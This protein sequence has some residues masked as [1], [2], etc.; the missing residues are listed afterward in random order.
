MADRA[1]IKRA[2]EKSQRGQPLTAAES[3]ALAQFKVKQEADWRDKIYRDVPLK[4]VK[5]LLGGRTTKFV[6][7][8][9]AS[10]GLPIAGESSDLFAVFAALVGLGEKLRATAVSAVS[11]EHGRDGHVTPVMHTMFSAAEALKVRIGRGSVRMLRDW[12]KAGMPGTP[13]KHGGPGHFPIDEMG[14]WAK[15]NLDDL[16]VETDEA[17]L[18]NLELKRQKVRQETL[19]TEDREQDREERRGNILPRDELTQFL[20]D[21]IVVA[22]QQLLALPKELAGLISDPKLQRAFLAEATK[23]VTTTLDG[24]ASEF[25]RGPDSANEGVA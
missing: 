21:S 9:A 15:N 8:L 23:K 24:L 10:T 1:L 7:A 22:R 12:I 11:E 4:D 6:A 14:E 19:H 17:S 25:A 20:R 5:R 13:G 16:K 3:K 18:L 2:A